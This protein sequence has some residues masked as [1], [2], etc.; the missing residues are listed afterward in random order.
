[1]HKKIVLILIFSLLLTLFFTACDP[2]KIMEI[3]TVNKPNYSVTIYGTNN[4]LPFQVN[5]PNEKLVLRFP[6]KNFLSK[7]KICFYYGIGGW[8]D[9]MIP[10][11]A[12]S[13]DSIVIIRNGQKQS[14]ADQ[15]T[16]TKYL[17]KKRY[18]FLNRTL[19]IEAKK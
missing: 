9:K 3:R 8:S 14:L 13:F 7:K 11:F 6:D 12:K 1:M 5:S 17:L 15:A 18:G 10:E 4:M 2:A 16:I 19:I